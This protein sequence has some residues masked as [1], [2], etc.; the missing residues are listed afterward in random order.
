MT[1]TFALVLISLFAGALVVAVAALL[2]RKK[3]RAAPVQ[4]VSSRTIAEKVRSV[5]KLVGVEVHA[6]E[7][8]TSTKGWSWIPSLLLS[9]ARLAMIFHFE[10]QYYVDLS[11]LRFAD[12]AELPDAGDGPAATPFAGLPGAPGAAHAPRYRVV[13]PPIEG[14]LRLTE[15]EPYDIQA[16]R[17]LGLVDVIQMDAR[18]QKELMNDAQEQA[19]SLFQKSESRYIDAAQRS[20]AAHLEALLSLFGVQ[21]IVEWPERPGAAPHSQPVLEGPQLAGS[22]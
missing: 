1:Q 12:V 6:K 20:I 19:A 4:S 3:S 18:T 14:S 2:L 7:I 16:G 21:A 15:I 10:K 8:T 9:Q 5:G 17:V 13:M 22:R 11:R